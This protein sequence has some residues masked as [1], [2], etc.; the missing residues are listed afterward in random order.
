MNKRKSIGEETTMPSVRVNALVRLKE[1]DPTHGVRRG[2]Q[3]TVVSV[4]LSPRGFLCEV[5][6]PNGNGPPAVRALLRAEQLEIA[7]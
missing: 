1:D 3:G 4:W 5:E 2:A 6:F 7:E